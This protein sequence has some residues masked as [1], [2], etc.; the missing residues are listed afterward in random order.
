MSKKSVSHVL[1]KFKRIHK[2]RTSIEELAKEFNPVIRGGMQYY[3]K[4][5]TYHTHDLWHKL[6]NRLLKWVKWEKGFYKKES[7]QW[8]KKKYEERPNLFA[9]WKLVH[10]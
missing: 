10:P 6:N 9:H 3:C 2:M 8:L 7:V 5:W 1:D 4:F